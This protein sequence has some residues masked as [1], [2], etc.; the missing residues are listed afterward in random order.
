MGQSVRQDVAR[1]DFDRFFKEVVFEDDEPCAARCH[2]LENIAP[3]LKD[4]LD[5]CLS[6]VNVEV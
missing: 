6:V 3:V 2:V 4:A 1:G 5:G